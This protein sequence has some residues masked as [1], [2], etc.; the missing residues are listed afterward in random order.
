VKVIFFG[1]PQFA[2]DVL[3]HLFEQEIEIVAIVTKPDKPKG[4]SGVPAPSPVKMKA[5]SLKSHIPIFQPDLV[6]KAELAEV[7][8]S[9]QADL[10]VVV[11]YGEIIKQHLLD[12]PK[13]G[14]INLHASLLPKY[15]GA[16]PIQQCLINGEIES[17]ITIMQMVKKMDAGDI[18]KMV[19]VPIDPDITYGEL[20]KVLCE[21]GKKALV[22]VILE[23]QKNTI[24]RIPQDDSKATF[25]PKIELEGC[26]INW[27]APAQTVHNLVRGVN[28]RPGAW[29]YVKIKDKLLRL[30]V[31]KTQLLEEIKGDSGKIIKYGPDSLIIS[32]REGAVSLLEVQL[33]GKKA[34]L[35]KE[36]IRGIPPHE[37]VI[38]I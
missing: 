13:L 2:A 31:N 34:M 1:T 35:A 18:I 24:Q 4:R 32:C 8:S 22:D 10:F 14:C 38:E 28:P 7:F 25:C 11:A 23:F 12:M 9:F 27:D 3:E 17:G 36:M 19:K 29:S 20:E 16:A 6:S 33:E 37:F 21:V 30:K 26:K 15:R 5:N